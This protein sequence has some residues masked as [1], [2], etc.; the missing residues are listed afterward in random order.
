MNVRRCRK[1]I[2]VLSEGVNPDLSLDH[3]FVPNTGLQ[4]Q[5]LSTLSTC[6]ILLHDLLHHLTALQTFREGSAAEIQFYKNRSHA[7]FHDL[8]L[9]YYLIN[10]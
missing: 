2:P 5:L 9:R 3:N 1:L 10:I 6:V 7:T 4:T 8:L